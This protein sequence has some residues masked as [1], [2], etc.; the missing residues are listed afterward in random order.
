MFK[1]VIKRL[2]FEITQIDKL[3]SVYSDLLDRA[4]KD[5]PGLVECTAI[6]SVLHSFYNGVENICLVI[7]KKFD[8][9]VPNGAHWHAELLHKMR[10][11]TLKR[12]PVLTEQSYDRLTEYLGF[13]HLFRHVYPFHME[14]ERLEEPVQSLVSVWRQLK[15]EIEAFLSGLEDQENDEERE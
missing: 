9:N 13:R 7:A 15:T 1:E 12:P 6:A 2:R 5:A 14:W 10:A 8:K 3:L 4:D 11:T